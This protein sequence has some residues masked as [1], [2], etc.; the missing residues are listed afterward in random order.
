M[1]STGHFYFSHHTNKIKA[2]KKKK[3]KK[4][5]KTTHTRTAQWKPK[6]QNLKLKK[7]Q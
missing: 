4:T 2:P 7:R 5:K 1:S 6:L 3:K